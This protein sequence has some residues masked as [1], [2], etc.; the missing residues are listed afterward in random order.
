MTR[1]TG[2]GDFYAS[3]DAILMGSATYKNILRHAAWPYPDK[4]CWVLSKQRRYAKSSAANIAFTGAAP[5]YMVEE[6]ARHSINSPW[7][8]GGPKLA[9]SF[10]G[11]S[12]QQSSYWNSLHPA[13]HSRRRY[14]S[15]C[16]ARITEQGDPQAYPDGAVMLWYRKA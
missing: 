8:V 9:A 1:T 6:L 10:R 12:S 15:A 16:A 3:V 2:Y 4:R 11:F 13:D 7:I 14:S 5:D